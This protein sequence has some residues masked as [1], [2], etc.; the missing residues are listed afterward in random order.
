MGRPVSRRTVISRLLDELQS[1]VFLVSRDHKITYANAALGRWLE[2][3]PDAISGLDCRYSAE[4]DSPAAGLSPPP[5]VF[6]VGIGSASVWK[7]L[8]DGS[9]ESRPAR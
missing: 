4:S 9:T 3:E 5:E 6:R 2:L 1:P 7:A 8:A